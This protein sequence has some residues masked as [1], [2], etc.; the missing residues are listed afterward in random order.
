MN[1]VFIKILISCGLSVCFFGVFCHI[2]VQI[3]AISCCYGLM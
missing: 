2:P 1:F 3:G